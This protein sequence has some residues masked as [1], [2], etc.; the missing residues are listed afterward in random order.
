SIFAVDSMSKHLSALIVIVLSFMFVG[1]GLLMI[2][3]ILPVS[4]HSVTCK[5]VGFSTPSIAEPSFPIPGDKDGEPPTTGSADPSEFVLCVEVDVSTTAITGVSVTLLNPDHDPLGTENPDVVDYQIDDDNPKT[6]AQLPP[7]TYYFYWSIDKLQSA[8]LRRHAE[9][10]QVE[11]TYSGGTEV[12]DLFNV[13]GEQSVSVS[14]YDLRT[15]QIYP[16]SVN[17]GVGDSFTVW[18]KW[19]ERSASIDE[20]AAEIYFRG[21][22][23]RL[24]SVKLYFYD[25]GDPGDLSQIG[26][27]PS[28]DATFNNDTYLDS[29]VLL[30]LPLSVGDYWVGEFTFNATATGGGTVSPYAQTKLSAHANWKVGW[31]GQIPVTVTMKEPGLLMLDKNLVGLVSGCDPPFYGQESVYE[32]R[33]IIQNVGGSTVTN[34]VVTDDIS[35]DVVF[36]GPTPLSP[37]EGSASFAS[38]KITWIG[39]DLDPYEFQILYFRVKVPNTAPLG[40]VHLNLGPNLYA[41]GTDTA[42]GETVDDYGDHDITVNVITCTCLIV[43]KYETAVIS[44][45]DPPTL[46]QTTTYNITIYVENAGGSTINNVAVIDNIS[47]DPQVTYVS[48]GTPSQGSASYSAGVITWTVGNLLIGQQENLNFTVSVMPTQ[49]GIVYLNYASDLSAT[50]TSAVGCPLSYTGTLNVTE[51]ALN[52]VDPGLLTVDKNATA[53]ISGPDPPEVGSTTRY[54]IEI[55]VQNIGGSPVN[56]VIVTDQISSDPQVT[57]VSVGTPSQGSASYS[58]GVITW[59]GFSLDAGESATLKFT[60]DVTPIVP[61]IVY[62]NFGNDLYTNGTDTYTSQP[63]EDYGDQDVVKIAVGQGAIV[64][65]KEE[66]GVVSGPDPLVVGKTTVYWVRINLTNIGNKAESD[67]TVTNAIPIDPQISFAGSISI[68]KGSASYAGGVI[69]WNVDSLDIQESAWLRYKVAVT[70]SICGDIVLNWGY[71]LYAESHNP[72]DTGDHDIVRRTLVCKPAPRP[73][74]GRVFST[75]KLELVSPWLVLCGLVVVAVVSVVVIIRRKSWI[76]PF[77]R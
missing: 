18:I 26:S 65:D 42:T 7:G 66:D 12:S 47:S 41:V 17:V 75:K 76:P 72:S 20:L 56:D 58:A 64:V 19:E 8:S 21:T 73:V 40:P 77:L 52:P 55:K 57:Y 22:I 29:T 39:L 24:T 54:E 74:G 33:I 44:G 16:S 68:S 13:V 53:V 69:T 6:F 1:S 2:G 51:Y 37:T 49:V 67:I 45:P 32:L 5:I 28:A 9:Q 38:G 30:G 31:G 71:D 46:S 10:Y 43:E 36:D 59:D 35:P 14:Q 15:M 63:I 3:G 23:L 11:V 4:A 50:G 70:P 60:V 62:L 27:F 34:V 25:G 61:G 48:V